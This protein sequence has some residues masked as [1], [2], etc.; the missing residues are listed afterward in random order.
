MENSK[1]NFDLNSLVEYL[2]SKPEQKNIALQFDDNLTGKNI[3]IK[4]KF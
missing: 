3:K 1:S 4:N 2:A